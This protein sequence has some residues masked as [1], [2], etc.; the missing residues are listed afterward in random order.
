MK[1][2]VAVAT[3]SVHVEL[4]GCSEVLAV[5]PHAVYGSVGDEDR[6][7]V[8]LISEHVSQGSARGAGGVPPAAAQQVC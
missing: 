7:S 2:V 4:P 8:S 5:K 6:E 3:G 1:P